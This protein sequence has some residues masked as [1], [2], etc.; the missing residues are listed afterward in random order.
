VS[1]ALAEKRGIAKQEIFRR[2]NVK[3]LARELR[4]AVGIADREN[5]QGHGRGGRV[6]KARLECEPDRGERSHFHKL[7]A[8][9]RQFLGI[10]AGRHGETP[11][12]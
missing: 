4:N 6:E 7:A 8:I 12:N 5:R 3:G 10:L 1:R 2:A 9:K 11:I